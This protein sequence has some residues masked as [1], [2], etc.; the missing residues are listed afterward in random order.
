MGEGR[1]AKPQLRNLHLTRIKKSL[2]IMVGIVT[3]VG[4]G[5]KLFV[6]D[7]YERK[8]E[9]FYKHYDAEKSLKRMDEAG[10]MQSTS[11]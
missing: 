7:V 8:M 3:A 4:L 5:Y 11:G 6:I 1:L 2:G 9:E 10:L